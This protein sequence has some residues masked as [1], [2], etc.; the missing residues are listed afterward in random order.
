VLNQ[1]AVIDYQT[2][3]F[4]QL[5]VWATGDDGNLYNHY[6]DGAWHW[7]NHGND[8]VNVVG[9]PAV[10]VYDDPVSGA[11]ELQVWVVGA[12]GHLYNRYYDGSWNWVDHGT[13]G[14]NFYGSPAVTVYDD[15]VSGT[16]Q[17]QVWA[18][19]TN[20]D[21]YNHY[22]DGAWN[23]SDHGNN[24]YRLNPSVAPAVTVY[25]DPVAGTHQLQVWAV[26]QIGFD[27]N[28]YNH[29]YDGTWHWADHGSVGFYGGFS[30]AVY[31]DPVSGTHQL[32]LWGVRQDGNLYNHYYDGTWHWVNHGNDG[33][34]LWAYDLAGVTVY[35]DPVS[36]T[37][38]LQVWATGADGNLYNHYYDGNW[39]WAN[40]G[41]GGAAL[42]TGP[43]VWVYDDPVSGGHQLQV[44]A[45]AVDGN[46]YNH[47]DDGNGNWYWFNHGNAFGANVADP[48]VDRVS[49]PP[50]FPQA[51]Q[52]SEAMAEPM[53]STAAKLPD[54]SSGPDAIFF[55]FVVPSTDPQQDDFS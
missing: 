40:Y 22:F 10:T 47:Y 44:W 5:Q 50:E 54:A 55:S 35:D 39:H 25:D 30:L 28:L 11:H 43:A 51:V 46:L 34:A 2:G 27:L 24:G 33:A 29:Y 19:G 53:T 37:H 20:G 1:P 36:G 49:A 4:D 6:Y 38:Q 8:G 42:R 21:L 48:P 13:D 16:H 45:A 17:L 18:V 12:D 23:W 9:T 26:A 41:T 14:S 3:G 15:P 32:Q 31:D 7:A 52:Q